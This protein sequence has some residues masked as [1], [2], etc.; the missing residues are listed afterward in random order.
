MAAQSLHTAPARV[1][2]SLWEANLGTGAGR[3]EGTVFGLAEREL[4]LDNVLPWL[5]EQVGAVS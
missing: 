4:Q 2:Q 5:T 1:A 3:V